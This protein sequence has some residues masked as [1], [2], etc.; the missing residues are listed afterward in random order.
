MTS[1]RKAPS[2]QQMIEAETPTSKTRKDKERKRQA[3]AEI[4]TSHVDV[5][6]DDFW[7]SNP[8]LFTDVL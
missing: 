4:V 8:Y 3:K 6:K 7:S 1:E 5:I 2:A